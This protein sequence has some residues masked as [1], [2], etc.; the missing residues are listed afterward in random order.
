MFVPVHL[1]FQSET[2]CV[3]MVL[4]WFGLIIGHGYLPVQYPVNFYFVTY[5]RADLWF[6]VEVLKIVHLAISF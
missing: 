1:E 4:A 6:D 3:L 5:Q 2:S